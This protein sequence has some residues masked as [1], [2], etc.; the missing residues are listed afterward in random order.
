MMSPAAIQAVQQ[1]L[2]ND[3]VIGSEQLLSRKTTAEYPEH[4]R[5]ADNECSM[6]TGQGRHFV[7]YFIINKSQDIWEIKQP[8]PLLILFNPPLEEKTLSLS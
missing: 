6:Q 8:L 1:Q 5:G 2:N 4:S 7:G 3:S